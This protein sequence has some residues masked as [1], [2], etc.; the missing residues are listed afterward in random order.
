MAG[1]ANAYDDAPGDL[2]TVTT[3]ADA[4]KFRKATE[5]MSLNAAL[6]ATVFPDT[7]T[8]VPACTGAD[9][10]YAPLPEHVKTFPV[11]GAEEGSASAY[12]AEP[13]ALDTVTTPADASV[14]CN[15]TELICDRAGDRP[16]CMPDTPMFAPACNAD[17]A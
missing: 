9:Q 14:C 4:S 11:T 7:P 12:D 17:H 1:S 3:P 6:S 15:A 2:D 8:L 5:L 10:L 16:T 13:D